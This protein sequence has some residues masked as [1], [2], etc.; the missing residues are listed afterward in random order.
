M[1]R[2]LSRVLVVLGFAVAGTASASITFYE[3]GISPTRNHNR[4]VRV[5]FRQPY[6]VQ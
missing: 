4:P 3:G 1:N 2:A 5:Q 6:A